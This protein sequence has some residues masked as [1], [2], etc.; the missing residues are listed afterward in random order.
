MGLKGSLSRRCYRYG[1]LATC[2][3]KAE[4]LARARELIA[5]TAPAAEMQCNDRRH[6]DV[7]TRV[8]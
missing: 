7:A 1:L 5:A 4:T 8:E 2:R 3:T 6:I